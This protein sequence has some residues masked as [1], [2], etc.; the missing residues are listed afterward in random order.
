MPLPDI[1]FINID[2]S[3]I[4]SLIFT[5]VTAFSG[6]VAFIMIWH[7][8]RFGLKGP[9][10]FVMEAVYLVGVVLLVSTAAIELGKI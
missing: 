10:V 1:P 9:A 7:W 6:V 2:A 5:L 4:A 8:S 3:G